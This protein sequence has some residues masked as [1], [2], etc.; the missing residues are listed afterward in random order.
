MNLPE[1]SVKNSVFGNMLTVVVLAVGL[2][3]ALRMTRE[4]FPQV[5]VDVVSIQTLYA[6]ASP[7]EV[8]QL[9]T[10]PLEEQIR[11]VD[12]L[13]R[14]VST[15]TESLSVIGAF[16]DPEAADKERIINEI[17][18]QVDRVKDFP[19]D[20]ADPLIDVISIERPVLEVYVSG[21]VPEAELQQFADSLKLRLESLDDVS[22]VAVLGRRDREIWIEADPEALNRQDL[23]LA[24]IIRQVAKRN[25]NLPGGK[26]PENEK[27]LIIRTVGQF[28]GPEEIERVIVRSNPDGRRVHIGDVASVK[29]AFKEDALLF[30]A[31]GSRAISLMAMKRSSADAIRLADALSAIVEEERALAPAGVE[32]DVQD[33]NAYVIKRRLRVLLSNG[34]MGLVLVL[35]SF[36]LFLNLRIALLTVLG[37]PFAFLATIILMSFAGLTVNMMSMFGLILVLGMVVDDAIII[38]ENIYRHMEQG[39]S[40][41]EAAVLGTREVMYPVT[42]TVLTTVAAFFPLLFLPGVAGKFLKWVPIVVMMALSASLFEALVILP[43]HVADFVRPL[44]RRR[45]GPGPAADAEPA[46]A[47]TGSSWTWPMR[48]V[49]L[50]T[51]DNVLQRRVLFLA[52]VIAVFGGSVYACFRLKTM[53]VDL[54]P[55][56]LIEIF[57]VKLTAPRGTSLAATEQL[58]AQVER[59][60]ATLP[61]DEVRHCTCEVGQHRDFYSAQVVQGT[62][63]AQLQVFLAPEE[64]R[65]RPADAIIEDARRRCAQIDGIET[66]E[67]ERLEPGPPTG[68]GVEVKLVG[69][70]FG[71]LRTISTEVQAHLRGMSGMRDIQDDYEEGK[72]ELRVVPDFEEAARLGLSVESIA[73]TVY[74]AFQGAEASVLRE[75]S[76]EV[77]IRVKI[78][79]P[80]RSDTDTIRELKVPNPAGRLISLGK[81]TRLERRTGPPTIHH[82]NGERTV[83][84]SANV[85][86][87]L[88]P[89]QANMRL[90]RAFADVPKRYPGYRVMPGTQWKENKQ[91]VDFVLKRGFPFALLLIYAILTVQFRSWSQPFVVMAAIPLGMAGVVIALA[92]HGKPISMMALLGMVGLGGVVVNDAIVLVS[93]IN[94]LVQAGQPVPAAIRAACKARFRPIMLTSITTILGLVPVIYGLGGYEPFIAPAAIALA[95]GL[96]F[97]TV[98]TLMVVPCIY[99]LAADAKRALRLTHHGQ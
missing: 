47:G 60:I 92:C 27:E 74:A 10:V 89:D 62:R 63:Y 41:R 35:G 45:T 5:D 20:V 21:P 30:R 19:D 59:R 25:V 70:D 53:H 90:L 75:Q 31:N 88:S 23:S 83:T 48:A 66:L 86:Q 8:E 67:F 91:L 82:Y 36:L 1:F 39:L 22:S 29:R 34:W 44:R 17:S 18:R 40:P 61:R 38:A 6:N 76:D 51:L 28:A 50:R 87:G 37:I 68:K 69:P 99:S 58:A 4:L 14:L 98:L 94:E 77:K 52:A 97:A 85:E 84:V 81:V 43:C 80:F 33:F 54:F 72:E 2:G 16:L 73:Q 24:Q 96:L 46:S 49:Y 55:A 7:E 9:V 15:S 3:M 65:R 93:F 95:Y 71:T 56:D 57:F 78:R 64:H 26:V 32:L 79:E 42:A 11:A 13:E 12:G